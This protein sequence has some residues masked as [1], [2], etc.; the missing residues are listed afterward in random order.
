MKDTAKNI[1]WGGER[2]AMTFLLGALSAG[3]EVRGAWAS[4]T[5][6]TSSRAVNH[7]SRVE[8]GKYLVSIAGCNE[9]HTPMKIGSRGPE[10]DM[11]RML[12]GHPEQYK[13]ETS[14]DAALVGIWQNGMAA[15]PIGTAF[16]GPWGVSFT[17]N[18]TPDKNTGLGIWTE[19]MFVKAIRTGKH[20]GVSRAIL[21]P[22]PWSSFR[23][24]TDEDLKSIFAYLQTIPPVSNHVPDPIP[25]RPT[26]TE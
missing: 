2:V 6:R 8:R 18:L 12:S 22:M 7:T 24:M 16:S 4:Y 19:D 5:T 11:S 1:T 9:C 21:P 10:P 25:P 23:K 13:I 20:F 3:C 26:L 17:A 15:A 14:G